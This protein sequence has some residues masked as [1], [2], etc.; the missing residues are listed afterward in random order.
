M[1]G[2]IPEG[3]LPA[4]GLYDTEVGI[5]SMAEG[6]PHGL[7]MSPLAA[8]QSGLRLIG[9]GAEQSPDGGAEVDPT[10]I[11]IQEAANPTEECVARI[12]ITLEGAKIG[13]VLDAQQLVD[14][15]AKLRAV[16]LRTT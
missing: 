3:K 8:I 5:W 11:G 9:V 1:L 10:S 15:T 16:T 7:V 6:E 14:L 2:R 4:V 13:I 12:I